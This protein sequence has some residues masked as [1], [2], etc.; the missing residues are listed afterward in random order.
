MLRQ[1]LLAR[2]LSQ[3]TVTQYVRAMQRADG[4]LVVHRCVSL[5]Q[6]SPL[7]MSAYCA[8]VIP[9]TWSSRKLCKSALTVYFEVI[10]RVDAPVGAIRVPPKPRFT[11]RALPDH[12]ARK[13]ADTAY[14]WDRGAEGMATLFGMYAALRRF[15]IAKVRWD[16]IDGD[17]L[18][19]Q[20]K[21]NVV[22]ELPLHS[23]ILARLDWWREF[24][25][26]DPTD[27][28][29][30]PG[31]EYIFAGRRGG[32]VAPPT[33]W[34]WVKEVAVEA[35]IGDITTHQLRHTALAEANDRTKDLRATQEFAR[36]ADPATTVLYTRVNRSRLRGIVDALEY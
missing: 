34:D 15:E 1:S 27:T 16:D 11:C 25:I 10:G 14:H 31:A 5:A 4:W 29:C 23:R 21:G 36:H 7:D 20:G 19:V 17:W 24:T 2:G 9:E 3:R 12:E 33:V 30:R 32:H 26:D 6:A 22:A 8:A 18:R 28:R 35:G 13:L